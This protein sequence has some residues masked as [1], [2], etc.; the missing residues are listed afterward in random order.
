MY[1]FAFAFLIVFLLSTNI[2]A[3]KMDNDKLNRIFYTISDTLQGGNGHWRF[4][5]ED[6]PF[7]CLTDT[8]HNR[9]RIITPVVELKDVNEAQMKKCMEAN[10]HTA[11]DVKYAISDGILWVAFIHPLKELTKNQVIDAIQQV[12]S[13]TKTYGSTYT[14]GTLS[15]PKQ[16]DTKRKMN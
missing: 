4:G 7:I 6:V 12:Y 14:S 8:L 3:Q 16:E 9:M 15:F 11:L 5:I 1:K 10:F 13:A 2:K